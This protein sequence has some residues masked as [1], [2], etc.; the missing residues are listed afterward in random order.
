M[1]LSVIVLFFFAF[2]ANA[3]ID[4]TPKELSY[5]STKGPITYCVDPIWAPLEQIKTEN[6]L[7]CLLII[8]S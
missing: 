6:I 8:W 7:E 1:R 2:T 4:L 5:L 3:N